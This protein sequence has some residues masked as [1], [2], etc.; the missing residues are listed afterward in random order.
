MGHILA[1]LVVKKNEQWI[2]G[3]L[4]NDGVAWVMTDW[5]NPDMAAQMYKLEEQARKAK[6]GL[7]KDKSP[8]GV[9]TPAT[10]SQG[11]GTFRIVQGKVQRAATSNNNLYLNF[12]SD[13]KKDFTVMISASLR[14][15]LSRLGVDP[16]NLAG[17]DIRVRGWLREWN[18]PFMELETAERLEI[19][20][21]ASPT[22]LSPPSSTQTLP[23]ASPA[24]Q[25]GQ[26]NP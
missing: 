20:S 11:D 26:P 25:T 24:P 14:K 1:H 6:I 21:T 17:R 23:L 13:M 5:N 19:L 4:L 15:A 16:M 7:W 2:N 9:L 8:Y 22:E 10:A 18:G 12:G 3:T